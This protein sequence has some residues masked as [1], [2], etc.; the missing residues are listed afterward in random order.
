MYKVY[1]FDFNYEEND[2]QYPADLLILCGEDDGKMTVEDCY[3]N[4]E[5]EI[6]EDLER[7]QHDILE[8]VDSL[9]DVYIK[10]NF[11]LVREFEKYDYMWM[12]Y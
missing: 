8:F 5:N 12:G 10:S 11:E 6:P 9:Y 3:W 2:K 7:V 4:F 1:S